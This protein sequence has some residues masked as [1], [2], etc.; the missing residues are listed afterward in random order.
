MTDTKNYQQI[1][2]KHTHTG[3]WIAIGLIGTALV[4]S[5]LVAAG[6]F[7][8]LNQVKDNGPTSAR[9]YLALQDHNYALA[10]TYLD[11]GATVNNKVVDQATFISQAAQA[12]SLNSAI[13]GFDIT[14][15]NDNAST[16][17]NVHR[18]NSTYKAHITMQQNGGRWLI[19]SIDRL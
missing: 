14:G 8:G 2:N 17:V 9:F 10:Y 1:T 19:Q 11:S 13:K 3:V 5:L 16:F 7:L 18:G 4:L 15:Q 12:D 6:V